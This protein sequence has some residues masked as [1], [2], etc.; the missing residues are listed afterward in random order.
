MKRPIASLVLR[1]EVVERDHVEFR[2]RGDELTFFAPDPHLYVNRLPLP[3]PGMMADLH[4]LRF[5]DVLDYLEELGAR[6]DVANNEHMQLARELSYRTAPTPPTIVD[7]FYD[8]IPGLFGRGMVRDMADKSIGI[9]YL[10]G[11]VEHRSNSGRRV[12]VRAFGSRTLHIVAGNAPSLCALSLIRSAIARCDCI[13]KV[14]SNDPFTAGAIGR[15]MCDMAADHP[16]TRHFAVAYWRGGD[17][18]LEEVLYQPHNIEKIIAWGG[19]ASVRHVT[20]YI[21]P[22]L[23]LISLDPKRSASVVG[24]EAFDSES[25]LR[26]VALRIAVDVGG[27]NQVACANARVIYVMSGD[28]A[29]GIERLT[30]LGEYVYE[31]MMKLPEYLSTKPKSYDPELRA[32]VQPLRLDDEWFR[33]IGGEQ[34]EGCII[35]SRISEPVNFATRLAD[36]TANLVPVNSVEEFAAGVDAYTQTVGIFPESLKSSLINVLPLYGAQRFVSLGHALDGDMFTPQDAIEPLRRMCKW[37]VN[38]IG[39]EARPLGAPASLGATLPELE[40]A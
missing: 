28:D 40:T 2:G 7:A 15:T 31:A 1:G 33:V 27:M 24:P 12:A 19:L 23:E 17:E 36:R 39:D 8:S 21:Q 38:E 13:I 35:V 3:S 10:E 29:D 25:T 4:D 16:L 26:D 22:G 11:W 37:I 9:D 5:E 20:R 34:N 32:N 14:P 18:A 30:R 6:L